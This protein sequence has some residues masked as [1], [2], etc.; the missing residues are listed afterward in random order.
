MSPVDRL[1]AIEEIRRL[2]AEYFRCTDEKDWETLPGIFTENAETDMRA[3]VEPYNPDLL[4]YDPKAFAKNNGFVLEGVKTA[5]FGYMPVI[6][7][8]SETEATGKWSMED[9]LWVPEGNP[10]MPAGRM[11]GWGHY[12]DRY[13]KVDGHWLISA[14]K[15]LRVKIEWS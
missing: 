11:H 4:S 1:V 7:I 2:K 15:L 9:W 14:S 6:D 3:A 8:V 10:V 13:S 12:Y 5:H